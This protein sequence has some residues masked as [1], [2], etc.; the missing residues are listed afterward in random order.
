M[1]Y[2]LRFAIF[3]HE[4]GKMVISRGFRTSGLKAQMTPANG[5]RY[6]D[7]GNCFCWGEAKVPPF[8]G[9]P[10]FL[11]HSP[12]NFYKLIPLP[13]FFCNFYGNSL[14]PQIFFVTPM[15]GVFLFL[16][17]GGLEICFCNFYEINSS[18]GFFC[19]AKILVLMVKPP[20]DNF[21]LQNAN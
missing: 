19:I 15:C 3:P 21:S 11:Y 5:Q 6:L 10:P 14:R 18:Q 8:L 13:V 7:P 12:R 9:V 2:P 1:S 20:Q 4:T 16:L 17:G